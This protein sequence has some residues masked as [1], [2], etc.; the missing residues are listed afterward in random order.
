MQESFYRHYKVIRMEVKHQRILE[1]LFNTY[2]EN[3]DKNKGKDS[4][5]P[6]EVRNKA[7]KTTSKERVVCDYI[8]GMTDRYALL[9][10]KKLFDP[11]ERV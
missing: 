8:A 6:L 10:H 2:L 5:L 4:I 7:G 11:Q 9:E 1:E 3:F